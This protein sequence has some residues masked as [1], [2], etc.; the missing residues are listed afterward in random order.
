M[1]F[2]LE[3]DFSEFNA[4]ANRATM[5]MRDGMGDGDLRTGHENAQAV[6]LGH[7]R[8][9]FQIA[10]RG[11]GKWPDLAPSTKMQRYFKAGGRFQRTKGIKRADRLAQVANVP[12]P[13]LY[14]TGTL[15]TS[16]APGQ[17]GN[18][19]THSNDSVSAGTEIEYAHFHQQG[20]ARL[21]QR[22]ILT[23][24]TPEILEDMT[25]PIVAGF[26]AMIMRAM[27]GNNPPGGAI[28]LQAA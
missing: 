19:F 17:P 14:D 8:R 18:I 6:Y 12:F 4:F 13:I 25:P 27:A 10:S 22:I 20:G 3:L 15:Y 2:V 1:Q 24:P 21:P 7:M 26:R 16:L 23:Q 9:E 5:S 11:G 28:S